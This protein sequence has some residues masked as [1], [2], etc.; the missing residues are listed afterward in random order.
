MLASLITNLLNFEYWLS[1][2]A[3]ILMTVF[4]LW[5]FIDA[6]RRREWLWAAFIFIGWG[7]SAIFY[8][9]AVYRAAPSATRGFELP[10]AHSRR[11]IKQLQAQIHHLDKAHHYFQLGDIYFQ[12]GKLDQAETCYRQALERDPQDIDTLA[13]LGQCLLRKKRPNEA[14][15][16][17]EGVVTENPK[18]EYGY[19]QMALAET[20]TALGE[21]EAALR[22]WKQVTENHS[23]PRAKVQLAELYV[24]KNQPDLARAELNE[25]IADDAHAPTF[26]RRRDRIWI[27]RARS[28]LRK[29]P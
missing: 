7:I 22:I 28:L 23:Y 17:L 8:Y 11:R 24:S 19:S 5:M 1:N 2:P 27:R 14:R 16:L 26:Q 21:T 3:V 15:P 25:V 29:T 13:H 4:Q 12:Q 18:H 6:V 20:L 10:G 9:F